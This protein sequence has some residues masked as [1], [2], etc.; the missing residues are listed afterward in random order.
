MRL[1]KRNPA[2]TFKNVAPESPGWYR[3]DGKKWRRS[4]LKN[5]NWDGKARWLTAENLWQLAFDALQALAR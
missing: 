4:Y 2:P 3:F 1:F 5:P